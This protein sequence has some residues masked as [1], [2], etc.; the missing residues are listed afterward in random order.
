MITLPNGYT[1]TTTF[2]EDFSIAE[3]FGVQAIK[4]TWQNAFKSWKH[5]HVYVTELAIVMSNESCWWWDKDNEKSLLYA[6][7]YRMT[8]EYAMNHFKGA[9]LAFYINTTD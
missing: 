4:E 7:L 8:D 3:E 1:M 6:E 9:E 5:N 2:F